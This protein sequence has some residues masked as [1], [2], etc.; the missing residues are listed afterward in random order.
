MF[1]LFGAWFWEYSHVADL[2]LCLHRHPCLLSLPISSNA[3]LRLDILLDYFISP[4]V[5][6]SKVMTS[7]STVHCC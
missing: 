1:D 6:S 4:L 7:F 5:T 2:S 3:W